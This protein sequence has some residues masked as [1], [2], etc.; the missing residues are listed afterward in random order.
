MKFDVL[1][2]SIATLIFSVFL[3]VVSVFAYGEEN[4]PYPPSTLPYEDLTFY[5]GSSLMDSNGRTYGIYCAFDRTPSY[6]GVFLNPRSDGNFDLV[7]C[8][9]F[10]YDTSLAWTYCRY[11]NTTSPE[12]WRSTLD[13]FY[14]LSGYEMGEYSFTAPDGIRWIVLYNNTVSVP[15]SFVDNPIYGDYIQILTEHLSTASEWY[16]ACHDYVPPTIIGEY[17]STIPTLKRADVSFSNVPTSITTLSGMSVVPSVY[18][19]H[20]VGIVSPFT[21][22]GLLT[23]DYYVDYQVIFGYSTLKMRPYI[24]EIDK[25]YYTAMRYDGGLSLDIFNDEVYAWTEDTYISLLN[26]TGD[27]RVSCNAISI[28]ARLR[29]KSDGSYGD[30][31]SIGVNNLGYN[32]SSY[33]QSAGNI[34]LGDG[35]TPLSQGYSGIVSG[36]EQTLTPTANFD[37]LLTN[38]VNPSTSITSNDVSLGTSNNGGILQQGGILDLITADGETNYNNILDALGD[39]PQLFGVVFGFFPSYVLAFIGTAFILLVSIGIVK[40]LI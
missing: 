18:S 38:Q 29:R 30:W 20:I 32:E 24:K 4:P 39:V 13:H 25:K 22:Q 37:D 9:C 26:P 21:S 35:Y 17:D 31:Y 7:A 15:S 36:S 16:E 6:R 23:S 40:I 2:C 33:E 34:V 27:L 14:G 12:S 19:G 5:F 3:S 10:P 28:N 1:L 8:A 11:N